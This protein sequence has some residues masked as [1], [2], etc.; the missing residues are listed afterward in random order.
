MTNR[1]QSVVISEF[2]R[3]KTW[4]NLLG[5]VGCVEVTDWAEMVG[6][7]MTPDYAE[8]ISTYIVQLEEELERAYVRTL[9]ELRTGYSGPLTGKALATV[10]LTEFNIQEAKIRE[11]LDGSE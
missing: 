6:L 11:F 10:A 7:L 2:T 5:A 3:S 1:S 9:L 8:E 4:C